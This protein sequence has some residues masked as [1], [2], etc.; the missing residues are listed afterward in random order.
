MSNK[1]FRFVIA[2]ISLIV[3]YNKLVVIF[4]YNKLIEKKN[5]GW[6]KNARFEKSV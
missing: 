6:N 1:F 3:R 2:F 5:Y 4:T